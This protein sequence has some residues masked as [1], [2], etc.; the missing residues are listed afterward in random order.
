MKKKLSIKELLHAAWNMTLLHATD[1]LFVYGVQ[2]AA[3]CSFLL[4]CSIILAL[5][6]YFFVDL[7]LFGCLLKSY[8]QIFTMAAVSIISIF[9]AF[10]ALVFPIMYKQNGLDIVFGRPISG[11]DIN[12]RFFSYTIAMFFYW[13]LVSFASC[14]FFVPGLFL[15]Q[16]WRFVGLY[17]LDHGG[18]IRKAFKISSAMSCG[19]IWF[20]IGVSMVQW[21]IFIFCSATIIGIILAIAINRSIDAQIYKLLHIEFDKDLKQCS[22]EH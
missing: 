4:C 20:L 15:A 2:L 11:F 14:F 10:V 6:H 7:C 16:R 19:Y 1:W 9:G 21:L 5:F 3:I 13:S 8:S 22:C 17:L 18:N 12:N